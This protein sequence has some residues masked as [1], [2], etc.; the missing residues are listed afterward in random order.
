MARPLAFLLCAGFLVLTA[1]EKKEEPAARSEELPAVTDDNY[2]TLNTPSSS[3]PPTYTTP[4]NTYP[5]QNYTSTTTG[6][7]STYTAPTYTAPTPA[8]A[9]TYTSSTETL[10]PPSRS[11]ELLAPASGGGK[12]YTVKRGDSLSTISQ[13]QYGTAKRWRE[14]YNA[15]KARI[16][17]NPNKLRPGMKLIIP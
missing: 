3:T 13:K 1:C 8:P 4:S 10:P 15:N 16:G 7:D 6:G 2:T 11:D 17:K 12:T 14:I 9:P 5:T